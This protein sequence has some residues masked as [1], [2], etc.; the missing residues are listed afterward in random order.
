MYFTGYPRFDVIRLSRPVLLAFIVLFMGFG[1][2]FS[3]S[4]K[5]HPN[6]DFDE[7]LIY[8]QLSKLGGT[9][10]PSAIRDQILFLSVTDLFG[11]LKIK[12][13]WKR[14]DGIEG[15]ILH[16]DDTYYIDLIRNNIV[17]QQNRYSLPSN[18]FIAVDGMFYLRADY[19]GD[20]FGL[21]STFNF[22][23]LSVLLESQHDLPGMKI[24][25]QQMARKNL[26]KM[27]RVVVP[28][29]V[30]S[31]KKALA[32]LTALDWDLAYNRQSSAPQMESLEQKHILNQ[33]RAFLGL[34]GEFL[35]G[36][37]SAQFLYFEGSPVNNSN[38]QYQWKNINN[39]RTWLRQVR[40][41]RINGHATSTIFAPLTGIHIT[42]SSTQIRK[43]FGSYPINAYTEPGWMVELFINNTMIDFTKAD[44]AGLYSFEVPLNYGSTQIQ[45]RF[46]GPH[47]EEKF[48]EKTINVPFH[49]LRRKEFI[50]KVTAGYVD[51]RIGGILV[52]A[53]LGFGL[54]DFWT[55][56]AGLEYFSPLAERPFM[57]YLSSSIKVWNGFL[58]SGEYMPKVRSKFN[59]NYRIPS[60]MSLDLEYSK[61]D[62]D[63]KAIVFINFLEE[64]KAA[65][66]IPF[67][68]GGFS[69]FNRFSVSQ[70][71]FANNRV[72]NLQWLLSGSLLG[73]P[74]H[75]STFANIYNQLPYVYSTLSQTYRLPARITL[76]PHIQYN[77]N[78]QSVS[79]V[80][81]RVEKSMKNGLHFNIFF[82]N[83]FAVK[84][85]TW[86]LGLRYDLGFLNG[87]T[88]TRV[89]DVFT[90]FSQNLQGSF[91]FDHH[92]NHLMGSNLS[93]VGKAALT[94]MPFLDVNGNGIKEENEPYHH[95]LSVKIRGGKMLKDSKS[96][97]L[98]ILN[99]VPYEEYIVE[100]D[101][102]S[103]DNIAWRIKNPI[104]QIKVLPNRF[105]KLEI[106]I[107]V[108]H[109]IAG[110]VKFGEEQ[111]GMGSI[112]VNFYDENHNLLHSTLSEQDGF[113]SYMGLKPG[114]YSI[115]PDT[116]QLKKLGYGF[117]VNRIQV[118]IEPSLEG[119]Y[120]DS[121]EISLMVLEKS[122]NPNTD[123]QKDENTEKMD[124]NLDKYLPGLS[125]IKVTLPACGDTLFQIQNSDTELTDILAVSEKPAGHL[126]EI[127]SIN[128]KVSP[129]DTADKSTEPDNSGTDLSDATV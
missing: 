70:L 44:D 80:M 59:L 14:E 3:L 74:T 8:V 32:R 5:N 31:P 16:Q 121:F 72:T 108:E 126:P 65:L 105:N 40:V 111:S 69:V 63:Q 123:S 53:D 129:L 114:N 62:K 75:I 6:S 52:R 128:D 49:L 116:I 93:S 64:K 91:M 56:G 124:K 86:G 27:N 88:N 107:S 83:N 104:V 76:I 54:T 100:I 12:S 36:E 99:L 117:T 97:V 73:L 98:R 77:H 113:F 95:D 19:L 55:V 79:N 25:R 48:T 122:E 127:E 67:K 115:L 22:R 103:L 21:H 51:D 71:E 90:A 35:Y 94:I 29:T 33:S 68:K 109:E 101:P 26:N 78:L 45:L 15:Y 85:A 92:M 81:F 58:V 61:L 37:V 112:K 50:Y 119:T 9:E 46:Y 24:M 66:N 1:S 82:Q 118:Y 120:F 28:D 41:G 18:A 47:G 102:N 57:P 42:N 7:I 96:G 17:Y 110:Y 34:A 89:S 43:S 11:F 84:S 87:S 39:D 60:G 23:N 30:I 125:D 10:I 2:F 20:I 38:L 4:A 106:P 13:E